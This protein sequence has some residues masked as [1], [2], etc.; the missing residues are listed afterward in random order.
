[1]L[2]FVFGVSSHCH[3]QR[4]TECLS[5]FI[6]KTLIIHYSLFAAECNT[7]RSQLFRAHISLS[8]GR[9]LLCFQAFSFFVV[10]VVVTMAVSIVVTAFAVVVAVSMVVTCCS[11][12]SFSVCISV[13]PLRSA[14]C[15]CEVFKEPSLLQHLQRLRQQ[16]QR[17]IEI[18]TTT[19]TVTVIPVLETKKS[20]KREDIHICDEP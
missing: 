14:Y 1:M 13:T 19:N 8:S 20:K 6:W 11:G 17:M 15:C 10:V 12:I 2:Y 3:H 16:Q 4:Y 9:I 5:L 7:R 18:A